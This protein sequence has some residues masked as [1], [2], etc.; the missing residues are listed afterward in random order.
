[1]A[2]TVFPGT[3]VRVEDDG[4]AE[5]LPWYESDSKLGVATGQGTGIRRRKHEPGVI[6]DPA[7]LRKTSARSKAEDLALMFVGMIQTRERALGRLLVPEDFTE[8]E[9]RAFGL[10]FWKAGQPV[11]VEQMKPVAAL[12]LEGNRTGAS[13]DP[14]WTPTGRGYSMPTPER[15]REK[16]A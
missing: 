11:S 9:Y 2:E 4:E 12:Y 1:M 7:P 10:E 3:I 5:R 14:R 13:S 15:Y 6:P 8:A 16:E